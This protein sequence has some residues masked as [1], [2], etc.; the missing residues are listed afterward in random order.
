M[1]FQFSQKYVLILGFVKSLFF[2]I[3]G[4]INAFVFIVSLN[5][6]INNKLSLIN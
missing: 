3:S 6:S 2:T 4:A 5:M 1:I